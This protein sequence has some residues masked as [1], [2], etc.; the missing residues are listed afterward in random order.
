MSHAHVIRPRN[1]MWLPAA[2]LMA[3]GVLAAAGVPLTP[4]SG[5]ATSTSVVT[6]TVS[7]E[8]T[9]GGTCDDAITTGT[10]SVNSADVS[11]GGACTVTFSTNNHVPGIRLRAESD[12]PSTPA[13]CKNLITTATCGAVATFTDGLVAGQAD[14]PDGGFGL[15]LNATSTCTTSAGSWAIGTAYGLPADIDGTAGATACAQQAMG[16]GGSFNLSYRVDTL[17]AQQSGD[18]GASVLWLVEAI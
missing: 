12:R 14:L 7:P 8:L 1:L 2:I 18:Y 9:I 11:I 5:A 3:W 13:L 4:T 16:A 17:A 15:L 10:V 6:A